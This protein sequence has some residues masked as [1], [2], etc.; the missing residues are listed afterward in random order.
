[1]RVCVC[2]YEPIYV[3]VYVHSGNIY[4]HMYTCICGYI[5]IY[6]EVWQN[7]NGAAKGD[8][9][10]KLRHS[11]ILPLKIVRDAPEQATQVAHFVSE[12]CTQGKYF[13][14]GEI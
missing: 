2:L 14:R 3:C 9:L 10:Q 6:M 1:M 12:Y 4:A 7:S 11:N 8:K 5:Y 13:H